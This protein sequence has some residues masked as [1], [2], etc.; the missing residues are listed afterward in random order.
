MSLERLVM[1]FG[2]KKEDFR[3]L[4]YSDS[5]W[6]GYKEDRKSTS[7]QVFSLDSGAIT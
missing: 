1:E 6:A 7:G 2:I 4:G 5:N 3:F